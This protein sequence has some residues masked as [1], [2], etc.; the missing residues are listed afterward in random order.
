LFSAEEVCAVTQEEIGVERQ[1]NLVALSERMGVKFNDLRLLNEAL[2]HSSYANERRGEVRNSERLEFLG[3]AV[4]ELATSTYLYS[5]FP[6]LPEGELTKIRASIVCSDSLARL[7]KKLDLGGALLLGH[8]EEL[9]GG[10]SRVS[11]L[12][13]AFESVIGA[14]YLAYGWEV[15]YEYVTRQLV[16]EFAQIEN[17]GRQKDYKTMLQELVQKDGSGRV[18]Y[19]MLEESGPDHDKTFVFAVNVNGKFMG[20]GTGRS[21]K[22]AAQHAAK[23]ALDKLEKN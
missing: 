12:E 20:R 16:G 3:D 13:D 10:R 5:H 9:G 6:Q 4:L 23:I 21:K 15:A 14:V 11:N 1:K 7:A 17:G 18:A 22:E 8:G 19:E 2:T